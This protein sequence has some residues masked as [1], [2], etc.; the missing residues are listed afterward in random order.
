MGLQL[1]HPCSRMIAEGVKVHQYTPR[2]LFVLL[3]FVLFFIALMLYL[4][5]DIMFGL[6]TLCRLCLFML[7]QYRLLSPI[8]LPHPRV[9]AHKCKRHSDPLRSLA[10]VSFH[11]ISSLVCVEPWQV[12]DHNALYTWT[13][14]VMY[15]RFMKFVMS[16]NVT[17]LWLR[18][19]Q[20]AAVPTL[21]IIF[22]F[23]NTLP[24][25]SICSSTVPSWV[26]CL[27]ILT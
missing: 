14:L 20:I 25:S 18:V 3:I 4:F 17:S 10:E 1:C 2:H 26:N 5:L 19:S 12:Q 13:R 7:I 22:H 16:L 27:L 8:P 23:F 24:L 6:L 15:F 9:R 21:R 11:D